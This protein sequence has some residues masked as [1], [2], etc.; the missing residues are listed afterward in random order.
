MMAD[1]ELTKEERAD[2]AIRIETALRACSGVRGV[3]RSGSLVSNLVRA[4]A[5][6]WGVERGADP[7]VSVTAAP[8]GVAVEAAIGVDGRVSSVATLRHA[9][10]TVDAVLHADGLRRD[11][12]TLTVAYVQSAGEPVPG[13]RRRP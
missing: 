5:A 8:E 11:R 7:I 9:R 2:L 6:A 13:E 4:G 3:Y 1:A 10:D 12:L